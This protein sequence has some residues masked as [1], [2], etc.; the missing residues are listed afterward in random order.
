MADTIS[1]GNGARKAAM[2]DLL[3]TLA[4]AAI[5]GVISMYGATAELKATVSHLCGNITEIKTELRDIRMRVEVI[6]DRQTA[7][8]GVSRNNNTKLK[9]GNG[10]R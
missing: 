2:W 7:H 10:G 1:N 9:N 5:V 4:V 8:Y 3:K 6:G